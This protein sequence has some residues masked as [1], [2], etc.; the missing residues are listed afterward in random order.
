M[1]TSLEYPTG[2]VAIESPFYV[3]RPPVE[4]QAYQEITKPGSLIRIKAPKEM[5]KSSLMLRI[6]HHA[7]SLGYY[8]ATVDLQKIDTADFQN[9]DRFL[10]VFCTQISYALN[11][12]PNLD[13]YW[14]EDLGSKVNCTLY[15]QWYLLESIHRPLLL[16]INELSLIF[17]YPQLAQEFL[18]L[19]RSWFE[20]AKQVQA[21]SKLRLV[22]VY[23]T[24]VYVPMK[25][26]Q[27]PFNIGL[28]L[29]LPE[30]NRGQVQHL[31]ELHG[32]PWDEKKTDKLMAMVGGHPLLIRLAFYHLCHNS[33]FSLEQLLATA[34]RDTGIYRDHLRRHLATLQADE[35]LATVFQQIITGNYSGNHSANYSENVNPILIY[36]LESL[37]LIKF[38]QGKLR[39]RCD[40][41]R[42]YLGRFLNESN[43]VDIS[44]QNQI[45][46]D[47]LLE[48]EKAKQELE[49]LS[50]IDPLTQ[51]ANRRYFQEYLDHQWQKLAATGKPLSII[52]CDLDNFKLYND[53]SGH[54]L[55]DNCLKQIANILGKSIARK[56]N[57]VARYGGDE[58]VIILPDTDAKT[59][60]KIAHLVRKNI[61]NLKIMIWQ[62]PPEEKSHITQ[63]TVSLGVATT[64]PDASKFAEILIAAADRALYD[65]K[66][67]GRNCVSLSKILNF[68]AEMNGDIYNE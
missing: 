23:S 53:L 10:R 14:D 20:E 42:I 60:L 66:K 40:L 30:F 38:V 2:P 52:F 29:N 35:Q 12:K 45:L 3:P 9:I 43:L 27:S 57:L 26:N 22:V 49:K 8:T 17:E 24:E 64:I 13:D 62:T 39:V 50:H 37:G 54:Q 25:I 6:N 28:P 44:T 33:E 65:C 31:S 46:R 18:P 36:K 5:G 7:K 32:L 48:L 67:A 16:C 58:F 4:E 55:G 41:Y 59:A 19:L 34:A 68:G 15:F 51:V 56:D 21:W 47:R 63:I 1:I 61:E 11:L